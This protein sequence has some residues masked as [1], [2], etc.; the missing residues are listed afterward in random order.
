MERLEGGKVALEVKVEP[1]RVAEAYRSVLGELSDTLH[2]P[3]F[4]PGKAPDVVIKARMGADS[5]HQLVSENLI[6]KAYEEAMKQNELTPLGRASV[7]VL[8]LAEGDPLQF[9]A[10]VLVK[11]KVELGEYKGIEVEK[12]HLPVTPEMVAAE[13]ENMR[14][15]MADYQDV[16]DSPIHQGD[17]VQLRYRALLEGEEDPD[18]PARP[19]YIE[20]GARRY[21]P[22]ID[23]DLVGMK[24]GELKRIAVT[25]PEDYPRE[26]F[27]GKRGT[28]EVEVQAVQRRV[29]DPLDDVFAAKCG[30]ASIDDLWATVRAQVSKWAEGITRNVLKARVLEKVT[31]ASS[32]EVP[33]D[34]VKASVQRRWQE[35]E[36]QLAEVSRTLEDHLAELGKAREELEEEMA[37]DA[38]KALKTA[39]VVDAIAE[40]ENIRPT[41]SQVAEEVWEIA[42]YHGISLKEAVHR[43][44]EADELDDI[45]QR[46][47]NDLVQEFL[48]DQAR[49]FEVEVSAREG[50]ELAAE[51]GEAGEAAEAV[52]LAFSPGG[53][54]AA[55]APSQAPASGEES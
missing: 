6:P 19:M 16:S 5:L 31:E 42:Q 32:V 28:F 45:F 21:T 35:L 46:L 37:G 10:T 9:K 51:A 41:E 8:H 39:F 22:A 48:A 15:R 1:E 38:T 55:P 27:R 36:Q 13:I 3:G 52:P 23:D 43:L 24:T 29:L 49:P 54:E 44:D 20:V 30:A 11:P 7:D 26:E 4:R 50:A 18:A 33:G 47:R 53:S 12:P 34:L 25:Y 40:Q 2:I 14:V 17:Y